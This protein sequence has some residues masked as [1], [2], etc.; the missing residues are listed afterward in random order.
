RET[1]TASAPRTSSVEVLVTPLKALHRYS[2]TITLTACLLLLATSTYAQAI[3]GSI[4]GT[5]HDSSGAV[6]AGTTVS[7][8]NIAT[9]IVQTA[10][11]GT[12]GDYTMP[13]IAPGEYK[14]T[15][16]LTG[17][18][19]AVMNNIV[20]RLEQTTRVDF[21][22]APGETNQQVDVTAEAPLVQSTTS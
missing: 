19:T 15:A 9:G 6:V 22:L 16:K 20:V 7:A 12:E 17:F 3:S 14:V 4:V 11:S 5:V 21:V 10:V 2:T 8:T 1:R 18:S 13:R